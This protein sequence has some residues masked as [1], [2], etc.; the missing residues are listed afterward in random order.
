MHSL[1]RIKRLMMVA[2][3]A[4]TTMGAL[5]A[6]NYVKGNLYNVETATKAGQVLTYNADG[7]V[8]IV[9]ADA[10]QAEQHWIVSEL[11]GSWRIINPF[12]NLAV[13]CT[14]DGRV[15]MGENNGSDEFQ[16]W[17]TEPATDGLVYLIPSNQ[18]AKA[19]V[20]GANGKLALTDKAKAQGNRKAMFNIKPSEVSGFDDN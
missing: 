16:L 7:S 20:M 5:V 8:Q 4:V 19:A 11:A 2:L 12:S 15:E 10:A 14:D 18:P 6:Q 9:K 3:F 17:R 1:N 13:R